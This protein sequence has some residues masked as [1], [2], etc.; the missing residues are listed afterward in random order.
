MVIVVNEYGETV[1]LMTREDLL[2]ELVGEIYSEFEPG[3]PRLRRVGAGL[4]RAEGQVKCE[5]L[6]ELTGLRIPS[7]EALT[8]NGFLTRLHGGIPVRGTVIR[9]EETEFT[10]EEAT[11]HRIQRCL[12]R[13]APDLREDQDAGGDDA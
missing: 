4:Y 13:A 10:I 5:E 2:E 12:I 8:L 6:N 1:G 9:W 3:Q 11:R 7:E